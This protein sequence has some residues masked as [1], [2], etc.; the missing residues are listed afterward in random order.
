MKNIQLRFLILLFSYLIFSFAGLYAQ[1]APR[2]GTLSGRVTYTD[3]TPAD[4]VTI[5]IK[6]INKHTYTDEQGIFKIDDLSIGKNYEIEVKT[7]GNESVKTKVHFTKKHQQ[8]TIRLKNNEGIS[9]SEVA[10]SGSSKGKRAKEQGYAMN[11]IDTKEALLQNI[12]T[13]ELL[14]RSAGIKIRQ[15]AG[16][17]SDISFNLNGLSGNSVRIFIDGIPIRNY[18]RSFSLSSIPPSMIERIEVYKGVLPSELS[19][20]ALGGGINVVLK[21]EM[22]NSLTTSYSY[23]SF[24]THQWDLNATYRDKKS[25]FTANL[26]SFYNYTDNN[27]K[28]WGET[29]YVTDNITGEYT[30][31]KARRFHDKYY[32]L[33]IKSNFGFTRKKWADEFLLGFM[34]SETDK[35]IQTGATMQV[36]YGNRRTEYNS[37]MASLQYKKNDFLLKGLDVSTFTTYSKT[38]RQVI[39]TVP[40]IYT[41][42]GKRAIGRNGKELTWQ[43]GAE[44]GA[45]TLAMNDERNLANRSNIHYHFH[46]NHVVGVSYFL[47]ALTRDIDDA[48]LS[49][50]IR[51]RFDQRKYNKQIIGFNYDLNA[52]DN[53]LKSSLF[54]KLYYQKVYLTEFNAIRR[55]NGNVEEQSTIH[56][57]KINDKG[58]G[59][60]L[61]YAVTPK[62]MISA[63]AEKAIRLPGSTELLGNTS[64]GV[65][66]NLSLKPEYSNN[67]N[68]GLTLSGFTFG[69]HEIGG[70]VNLFVRDIRDMILRGVPRPSDD[71][72]RFENLGKVISKGVDAEF[73]YNWDKCLFLNANVSY[74]NALFNLEYDPNTGLKYAHYRSRLRNTPY[75]TAN[76][77]AEY[78]FNSL[79]QKKSRLTINYNFGYTHEFFKEWEVYG[80]VGKAIIPSQPLHDV[81]LTYTFPNQK[82]TLA[83]NAKNIFDTQVFDNYALQKPGRSIFGKV[84]FSVF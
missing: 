77:N 70:E 66:T 26:S 30:H 55:P 71:F 39:D 10:V 15:S 61:S 51:N 13:T 20:D 32:S 63:S 18:G 43:Q 74:T 2:K 35:D 54:Y 78:L 79:I 72:F 4:M 6:S 45:P 25:G 1:Q 29:I 38:N 37:S 46:K 75:F 84:T 16:M 64:E 23:G 21:K 67:A 9:L 81:G 36:V 50:D 11:V 42:E 40:Y 14:G 69:K 22:N 59:F 82:W 7:F 57:R 8:I 3:G 5:F 19:E 17:G 33:G 41:W 12:Q 73:R 80:A 47:G 62:I 68:L 27:Y 65:N 53:K 58:Y 28:V 56:D 48:M 31:V 49:Q 76:F 52:F 83:F 34:F 44:A 60:S 24:N